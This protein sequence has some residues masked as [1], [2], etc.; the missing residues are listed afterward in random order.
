MKIIHNAIKSYVT[1]Q[2]QDF[3]G[4]QEDLIRTGYLKHT[5]TCPEAKPGDKYIISGKFLGE[6]ESGKVKA[7]ITVICPKAKEFPDHKLPESLK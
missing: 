1:D 5:Y 2:K 4:D 7:E 3:N 6:E